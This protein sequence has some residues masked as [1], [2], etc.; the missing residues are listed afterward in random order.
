MYKL[1]NEKQKIYIQFPSNNILVSCT[2]QY[3]CF[4][5]Q[6]EIIQNLPKNTKL[7]ME[8]LVEKCYYININSSANSDYWKFS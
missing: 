6:V 7:D 2:I 5:Y 4:C 8:E 3:Y 1:M